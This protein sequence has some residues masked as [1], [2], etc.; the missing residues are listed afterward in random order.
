V[1]IW[2]APF[3]FL[4]ASACSTQGQQQ[5]T[6]LFDGRSLEGWTLIGDADITVEDG[7]IIGR[8]VYGIPNSFLRTDHVYGDFDLTL[9]FNVDGG[10]NSGVQFRSAQTVEPTQWSYQA[11]S[12]QLR[13]IENEPGRVFGYQAEIDPSERGWTAEIH[14]E[15]AR[16]WLQTF[17]KEPA[18][19]RIETGV[20]HQMRIRANGSNIRTWLNGAPVAI[21]EDSMRAEGFIALQVHSVRAPESAGKSVRFNNIQLCDVVD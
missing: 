6:A 21:L 16:G 18:A 12:G 20:W 2:V 9:D 3:L 4:I 19:I 10:F 17:A 15:R 5:C 8:A 7:V 14:E 11:G 1:R 13:E